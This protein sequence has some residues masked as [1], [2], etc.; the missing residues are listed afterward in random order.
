MGISFRHLVGHRLPQAGW[1]GIV[2]D[3]YENIACGKQRNFSYLA[4]FSCA[5]AS[6][7]HKRLPDEVLSALLVTCSRHGSFSLWVTHHGSRRSQVASSRSH[8]PVGQS[9]GLSM[10]TASTGCHRE[11]PRSWTSS[12]PLLL[13][14][15]ITRRCAPPHLCTPMIRLLP[16]RGAFPLQD[17]LT[18]CAPSPCESSP[19][20]SRTNRWW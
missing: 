7:V 19:S 13:R 11:R 16:Q 9:L 3:L 1:T 12:C 5:R 6:I 17:P 4:H 15:A 20:G 8:A 10:V 18:A 2:N 14:I